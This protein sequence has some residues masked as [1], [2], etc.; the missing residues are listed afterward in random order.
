MEIYK[1]FI[2]IQKYLNEIPLSERNRNII[3]YR[4]GLN[5]KVPHTLRDTG[6]AFNVSYE[7]VRQIESEVLKKIDFLTEI[8][9]D[10]TN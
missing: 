9:K 7:R 6:K 4:V 8:D 10:L 2:K 3:A 1:R 5:C